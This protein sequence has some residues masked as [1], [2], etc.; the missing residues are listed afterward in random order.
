MAPRTD[1]ARSNLLAIDPAKAAGVQVAP[2][3]VWEDFQGKGD[4]YIAWRGDVQVAKAYRWGGGPPM[5]AKWRWELEGLRLPRPFKNRG[6]GISPS[7]CRQAATKAFQNWLDLAGL[8]PLV[9]VE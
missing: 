5:S 7:Y 4:Y 6:K 9:P 1:P 2:L 3:L 8:A